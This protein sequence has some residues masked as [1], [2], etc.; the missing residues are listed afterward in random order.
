MN[1]AIQCCGLV[2]I[3]IVLYFY[4][5]CKKVFLNTEKTFFYLMLTSVMS[6]FADI[7]S[8]VFIE[9]FLD[10]QITLIIAK[11]YL[12]T[13]LIVAHCGL[14]YIYSDT[15]GRGTKYKKASSHSGI[16]SITV[17][18]AII[19]SPLTLV[20]D[21]H[22]VYSTGT[23][24]YLTYIICCMYIVFSISMIIKYKN[25]INKK[26]R[27]A[28]LIWI[29]LWLA[30]AVIQ[31]IYKNVLLV[32][33]AISMGVLVIYIKLENPESAIDRETGLFNQNTFRLYVTQRFASGMSFSLIMITFDNLNKTP[34]KD[35]IYRKKEI[36]SLFADLEDTIS[37]KT[38][39]DDLY[40]L[41]ENMGSAQSMVNALCEKYI[42]EN[43]SDMNPHISYVPYSGVT[44]N[45]EDLLHTLRYANRTAEM[46]E[47]CYVCI[48]E[49]FKD[50]MTEVQRIEELVIDAIENNRIEVFYQP[51]YS[52]EKRIFTSAEALVR[53]R[54]DEGK[55]IPPATFIEIAE[56]N[57]TILK[58]GEVV[59][60]NVCRL[61]SES[62]ILEYGL[63][64]I[65]VNLSVVQCEYEN[66]AKEFIDIMRKYNIPGGL[67]NLEITETATMASKKKLI[68]N[69]VALR[70][71][72]VGFS[73]DDF[74][75]GQSNLSYIVDMPVDIVKFD[76][77]MTT[78]YFE[79]NKA[80]Y[81]MDAAMHMIHGMKLDIV[82]EG[83]ETEEQLETMREL[84][85]QYVQG[86]YFSKPLPEAE[87][88]EYIHKSNSEYFQKKQNN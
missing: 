24:A 64:Y 33:F 27:D 73:L 32:S 8:V 39:D 30:A 13:I 80:K 16:L 4:L 57:G 62:D 43:N 56:R 10:K 71:Y 50:K 86:Y 74:G 48:D 5:T 58:L 6:I 81:V 22:D 77:G 83:V 76:R 49:D 7:I 40:V 23:G 59:F 1:I 51:I 18:L 52:T 61:I 9:L 66:L 44:E 36:I 3:V 11:I 20:K 46:V 31:L 26:R 88:I 60:E 2:V 21:G 68:N 42:D 72:G 45:V 85:I 63:E 15:Y 17:A 14:A 37:F 78:A 34:S 65:E 41:Y 25:I 53:I 38:N 55:L 87:Y 35:S 69:M 67:I 82:S 29:A 75:T 84:G 79:S 54:D 19:F 70:N 47:K 28:V 12:V